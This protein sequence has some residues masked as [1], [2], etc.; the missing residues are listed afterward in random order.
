MGPRLACLHVAQ[1]GAGGGTG[2]LEDDQEVERG[3]KKGAVNPPQ[4]LYEGIS[5]LGPLVFSPVK[6]S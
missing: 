2:G 5:S 3:E 1:E 4:I 6:W